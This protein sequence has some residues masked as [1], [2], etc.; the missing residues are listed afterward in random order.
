MKTHNIVWEKI[1]Q[2][3]IQ[4]VHALSTTMSL[5]NIKALYFPLMGGHKTPY[6]MIIDKNIYV[7]VL[8]NRK[9][10]LQLMKIPDYDCLGQAHYE[11]NFISSS[12]T[13]KWFITTCVVSY[14]ELKLFLNVN[15]LRSYCLEY[16]VK[17][18]TQRT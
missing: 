9:V 1:Q 4:G 10:F 17:I 15:F 11:I 18:S 3:I 12:S 16:L 6:S 14:R 5:Q 7:L 2:D 8:K 13:D